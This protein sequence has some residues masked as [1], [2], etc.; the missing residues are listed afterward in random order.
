MSYLVGNP[1]DR[2][3][4]DEAHIKSTL[5]ILSFQTGR[6]VK[7][8]VD[9]DQTAQEGAFASLVCIYIVCHSVCIFWTHY[10]GKPECSSFRIITAIF[11]ESN[12]LDFYGIS[13]VVHL[14]LVTRKPVF[15]VCDQIRLEQACTDTEVW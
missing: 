10:S 4:R 9:A 5:M 12:M 6:T 2:F 11:K 14:S 7:N 1:E 15:G 13:R 3:S 8:S